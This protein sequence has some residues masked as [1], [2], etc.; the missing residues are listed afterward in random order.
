MAPDGGVG[1]IAAEKTWNRRGREEE[2][3]FT[4][5]VATCEA[6]LAGMAWDVRFDCDTVAGLQ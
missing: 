1:D 6:G 5:V 4:S 3:F 2:D